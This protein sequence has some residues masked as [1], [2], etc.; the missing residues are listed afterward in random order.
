[1]GAIRWVKFYLNDVPKTI[2]YLQQLTSSQSQKHTVYI[3]PNKM[4]DY[5]NLSP[6]TQRDIQRAIAYPAYGAK[7]IMPSKYTHK[8]VQDH[9]FTN[10]G[11]VN[12]EWSEIKGQIV[13]WNF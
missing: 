2:T 6:E 1:M 12:I 11:K 7:N 4:K 10:T 13:I 3:N 5:Q 9:T 8:V